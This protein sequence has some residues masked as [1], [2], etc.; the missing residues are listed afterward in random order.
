MKVL[1]TGASG[2]L[3]GHLAERLALAGARLHLVSRSPSPGRLPGRWH[4]Q[5]LSDAEG[6]EA[7]VRR[8]EPELIFHLTSESRGG[9]ELDNVLPTFRNDLTCAVNCLV[10]AAR[11]RCRRTI[12]IGSLEEP[13][14]RL[15]IASGACASLTPY[16]VSK[17][18]TH[19]YADFFSVAYGLPLVMVILFMTYGPR[20]KPFK[21]IPY[22]ILTLLAGG[23]PRLSSGKRL[24]DWIYIDDVIDCLAAAGTVPD[25]EGK[26]VEVG[27]SELVSIASMA[28][29][30]ASLIPGSKEILFG[31]EPDRGHDRVA[32]ITMAA[33]YLGWRPRTPL[34]QGLEATIDWYRR[35][36]RR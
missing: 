15:G 12:I 30:I 20:Q 21:V 35:H 28:N 2:F 10:A 26:T 19:V 7:L 13:D 36:N 33:K 27:S 16:A 22:T 32:D 25:V 29:L 8:I 17:Y 14:R 6:T 18:A 11:V 31:A 3:G 1:I 5:D 24:V 9:A 4:Q 23:Q 34:R